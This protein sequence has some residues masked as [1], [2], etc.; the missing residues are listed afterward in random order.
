MKSVSGR[1][2][3]LFNG[4]FGLRMIFFVPLSHLNRHV[5][6]NLQM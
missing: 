1:W 3:V 2:S 5:K 4:V 6:I